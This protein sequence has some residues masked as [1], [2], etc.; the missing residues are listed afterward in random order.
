MPGLSL[1]LLLVAKL[2][3]GDRGVEAALTKSGAEESATVP[4][5]KEDPEV[6]CCFCGC[7]GSLLMSRASAFLLISVPGEIPAPVDGR[8]V[9]EGG[10]EDTGGRVR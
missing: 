6:S 8:D 9:E 2:A 3:E 4:A 10:V 7:L 1:L 5:P